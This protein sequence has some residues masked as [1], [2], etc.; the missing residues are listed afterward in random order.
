MN[1]SAHMGA[2]IFNIAEKNML[3]N[4]LVFLVRYSDHSLL[5]DYRDC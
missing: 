5:V 1:T 4:S 3:K 2:S